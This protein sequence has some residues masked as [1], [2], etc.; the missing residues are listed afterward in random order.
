MLETL[1]IYS[2][3][4]HKMPPMLETLLIYRC[5]FCQKSSCLS[6]KQAGLGNIVVIA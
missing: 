6:K 5:L 4:W 3:N 1:L 2:T